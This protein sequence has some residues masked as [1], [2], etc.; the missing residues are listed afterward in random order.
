MLPQDRILVALDTP[1]LARAK[2]LAAGLS[3]LIGGLKIG[4]EFFAAHGPQGV[5][6]VAGGESLF[7]DLKVAKS[8]WRNTGY[9][10]AFSGLG[11]GVSGFHGLNENWVLFGSLGFVGGNL[12]DNDDSSIGDGESSALVFGAVYRIDDD[13]TINFGLK[14]RSYDFDFDDG[15][16]QDYS[17]NGLFFGYQHIFEW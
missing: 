11:F 6:E 9:E 10:Q 7:L 16:K 15:N 8:E 1:D 17:L 4:K 2:A 5:R 12:D 3:G 13:D 14:L